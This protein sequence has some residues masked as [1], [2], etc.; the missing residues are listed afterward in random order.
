MADRVDEDEDVVV[1][2]ADQDDGVFPCG[3]DDDK[4]EK[5]CRACRSTGFFS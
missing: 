1:G 5:G 3:G 2:E 4:G